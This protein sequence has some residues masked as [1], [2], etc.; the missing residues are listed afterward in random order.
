[1]QPTGPYSLCGYSF[2]ACVAFEMG[3][4]LEKFNERVQLLMLDGSPSYVA[5]HTGNYRARH[6]KG[7]KKDEECDALTYFI[8]LFSDIDVQKVSLHSAHIF[9]IKFWQKFSFLRDVTN[10]NFQ[11]IKVFCDEQLEPM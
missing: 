7:N 2:G 1:M 8:Q 10:Q 4:Q 11:T 5:A 3:L 6:A 9:V